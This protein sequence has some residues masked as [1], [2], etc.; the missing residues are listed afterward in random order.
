[1]IHE[2]KLFMKFLFI[3]EK[4]K[5]KSEENQGH[6]WFVSDR[7]VFAWLVLCFCRV[8]FCSGRASET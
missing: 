3:E 1:M 4:V 5:E 7:A 2:S 8:E 6:P